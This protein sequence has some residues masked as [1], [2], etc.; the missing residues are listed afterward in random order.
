MDG[1]IWGDASAALGVI[2]R[3]GS[4]KTRHMD[5]G[6]LWAQQTAAE[7][8]LSF[9]T[10]LGK[11]NPADLYTKYLDE[12]TITKHI[13][14]LA[15]E[16][17]TGRAKEAPKLHLLELLTHEI[18][19]DVLIV[20]NALD[21]N[22]SLTKHGRKEILTS[23]LDIAR[24]VNVLEDC[25]SSRKRWQS[26]LTQIAKISSTCKGDVNTANKPRRLTGSGQQVL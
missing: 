4:G 5:T 24:T 26:K 10:V 7:K 9:H 1:E 6:L 17:T 25:K 22:K 18:H 14:T 15:Y 11:M 20:S 3:R 23:G 2:H 8:R 13:D 19:G 21:S 16:F 12:A